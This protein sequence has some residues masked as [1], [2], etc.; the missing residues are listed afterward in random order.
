MYVHI[1]ASSIFLFPKIIE[2]LNLQKRKDKC[3]ARDLRLA[4]IRITGATVEKTIIRLTGLMVDLGYIKSEDG[5]NT[6][7]LYQNK[8]P[9]N[10]NELKPDAEAEADNVLDKLI[11]GSVEK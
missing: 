3:N 9:F 8:E 1:M 6:Y 4:I 2:S 10:F 11:A 5:F 7:F